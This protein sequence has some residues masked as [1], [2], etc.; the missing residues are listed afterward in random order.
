MK[1]NHE[2]RA[3]WQG[4]SGHRCI[5]TSGHRYIGASVHRGIVT[6]EQLDSGASGH[7][8]V[9]ASGHRGMETSG[10]RSIGTLEHRDIGKARWPF[11]TRRIPKCLVQ[12]SSAACLTSLTPAHY[13]QA[14]LRHGALGAAHSICAATPWILQ[15]CEIIKRIIKPAFVN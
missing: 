14:E 12:N 3:R 6:S 15:L 10:H 11:I 5:G 9:G 7:Q 1:L 2:R 8:D 4:K 13:G